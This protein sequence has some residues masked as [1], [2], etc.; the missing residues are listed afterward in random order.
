VSEKT[1]EPTDKKVEEARKSGQVVVSRDLAKLCTLVAVG[2]LAFGTEKLWR[3]SIQAM[4][5]LAFTRVGQPFPQAMWEMTV[6]AGTTLLMVFCTLFVTCTV[7]GV[8]AFWGQFGV[9]ISPEVIKLNFDKLNPVNGVKQLFS[10]KK[11][12]EVAIMLLKTAVIGLMMYSV[13]REQ[14]P[15][16]VKLSGGEPKDIYFGFIAI[17]H[18][19]FR[20]IAGICLC[21]GLVD[22]GLQ[23]HSH[24]NSLKMSMDDIKREYRESEGDPMVKGMRKHIAQELAMSA[25][26]A[27]TENAN[28]VVVNPSHF[29]IAM[30]YDPSEVPVP[31]VLA[32]GKDETAQA[33]I[34]RA[35]ECG[36]PV[37]RHVWLARA[38][39]A[40]G[41]ADKVIPKSTYEAVAHVYAV[42]EELRH[43]GQA[44]QV[45]ELESFG[46]MAEG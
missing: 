27:N 31:L 29:A 12:G 22:F 44:G 10:K 15:T 24:T 28:A 2:E 6:A 46:E 17:L 5:N 4:M 13:I 20:T 45:F 1:E 3:E 36:I 30:R 38:L 41:Q 14:L 21:F 35:R 40:T 11:L 25:P 43:G 42:V 7:V 23:K 8:S 34:A 37:I 26:V 33:M 39:Y 9:L 16:I 32:K 19:V 18:S